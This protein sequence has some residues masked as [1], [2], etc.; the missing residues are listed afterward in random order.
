M[1]PHDILAA[2]TP[3]VEALE[4]LDI[5]YRVGG[6]VASSYHGVPRS[7]LDI[8]LVVDMPVDRTDALTRLLEGAFYVD[9]A[10]IRDAVV[11]ERSFNVIHLGS[12][13]K[14]DVFQLKS[15]P[16]DQSAFSRVLRDA[17]DEGHGARSFDLTTAEDTILHKLAWYRLGDECS[18]RQ[19]LDV[20]GVLRV[21]THLDHEYLSRWADELGL[22]EL[23]SWA[24]EEAEQ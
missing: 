10:M 5:P 16:F 3:F 14:I 17:L 11:H 20:I 9:A 6:S 12:M 18:Q 21:C 7:T 22:A 13:V 19:W 23:L 2:L 24:V 4:S 1:S 8:D 15:E